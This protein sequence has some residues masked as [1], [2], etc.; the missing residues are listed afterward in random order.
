MMEKIIYNKF[1]KKRIPTLPRV[2][3]PGRIEVVLSEYEADKAVEY[4]LTRDILGVDTETR[5]SFCKGVLH[6]VALLQVASHDVCFLFRLNIIGMVPSIIRLLEDTS[7]PKIGLSLHEDLMMLHRRTDFVPGNFIDL[8]NIVSELGIEDKSLRKL[9]A[10]VF[11]MRISKRMQ[12]SNW[13][14]DI[15]TD[16]Q[17]MYAATD[18]WT[19]INL[20]EE[21]RKLQETGDYQLVCAE[22]RKEDPIQTSR[23]N[24]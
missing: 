12:L 14:N 23:I 20:Y 13:E 21:L 22:E 3:F 15:L 17:K 1:D 4:L 16:K 10:N 18:A 11:N 9:Y 5:P 19:C 8:Q 6:N 24:E 2:T 7:V